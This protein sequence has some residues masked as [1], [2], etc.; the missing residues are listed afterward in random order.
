MIVVMTMMDDNNHVLVGIQ[1]RLHSYID[2]DTQSF[3]K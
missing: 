3:R 2:S 1:A